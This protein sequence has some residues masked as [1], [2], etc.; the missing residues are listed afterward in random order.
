MKRLLSVFI[1]LIIFVVGCGSE[2]TLEF[3]QADNPE[4]QRVYLNS[5][6]EPLSEKRGVYGFVGETSSRNM[7]LFSAMYKSLLAK[8]WISLADGISGYTN[9]LSDGNDVLVPCSLSEDINLNDYG[10]SDSSAVS[11]DK[12]L[13]YD[14][15]LAAIT[16]YQIDY[17][18]IVLLFNIHDDGFFEPLSVYVMESNESFGPT[19]QFVGNRTMRWLM[20]ESVQMTGTEVL[21]RGVNFLNVDTNISSFWYDSFSRLRSA[22][23]YTFTASLG[24]MSIKFE[25]N[26]MMYRIEY[27]QDLSL[28]MGRGDDGII[29][30][31][32]KVPTT[33]FYDTTLGK[34][35]IYGDKEVWFLMDERFYGK[36][37]FALFHDELDSLAKGQDEHSIY[38]KWALSG[39]PDLLSYLQEHNEYN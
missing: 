10:I 30:L 13:L 33:I 31:K 14:L 3:T 1:L 8:K 17:V 39:E 22:D 34:A 9:Y 26:G 5:G 21:V 23:G 38:A 4:S 16:V 7:E 35:F 6:I 32:K 29:R 20:E 37:V 28:T 24:D 18:S 19:Y 12:T 15:N 11:I 36:Y 2:Q 27:N 25:E